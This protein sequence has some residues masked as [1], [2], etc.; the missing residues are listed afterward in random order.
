MGIKM[1]ND[2][3]NPLERLELLEEVA[4]EQSQCVESMASII[5]QQQASINRLITNMQ[6]LHSRMQIQDT[7][8]S[9]LQASIKSG[10]Q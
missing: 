2:I 6:L 10:T 5:R 1:F 3:E 8:I 7:V 4:Q 9:A